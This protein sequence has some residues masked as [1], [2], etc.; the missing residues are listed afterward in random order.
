MI[1]YQSNSQLNCPE[2]LKYGHITQIICALVVLLCSF[3]SPITA[4]YLGIMLLLFLPEA[5]NRRI[6]NWIAFTCAYAASV[7]VASRRGPLASV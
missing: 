5:I 4:Y 2:R 3:F 6:V 1:N 7:S